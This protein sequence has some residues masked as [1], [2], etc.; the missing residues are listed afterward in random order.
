MPHNYT[1]VSWQNALNTLPPLH[2]TELAITQRANLSITSTSAELF[3][4]FMKRSEKSFDMRT[5]NDKSRTFLRNYFAR[6]MPGS[7]QEIVSKDVL[8]VRPFVCLVFFLYIW[9]Q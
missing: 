9:R 8:P 4:V 2:A 6:Q 1:S 5:K 3:L 7:L